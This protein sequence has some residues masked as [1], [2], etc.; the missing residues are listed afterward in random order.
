MLNL[1][2]VKLLETKIAKAINYVERITKEKGSMLQQEAELRAKLEAYQKQE[3]E[4]RAKLESYKSRIHELEAL[5]ARFKDDQGK[6]EE[7]ILSALDRLSQFEKDIEKS[8]LEKPVGAAGVQPK[9]A[10]D[11]EPVM[12]EL[13]TN[14]PESENDSGFDD[15]A[16]EHDDGI[17]EDIPDPLDD[18][19]DLEMSGNAS[20]SGDSREKG[21]E[22]DIF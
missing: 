7:S 9:K 6:I 14:V 16:L 20:S 13:V 8:L 3:A 22:L 11:M 17:L 5:V 21:G 2:Q 10:A 18:T 4:S 15:N 1:E 12:A 19:Q